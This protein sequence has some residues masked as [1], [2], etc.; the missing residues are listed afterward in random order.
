[1]T[2]ITK[3]T[4]DAFGDEIVA[5]A[6]DVPEMIVIDADVGKSMRTVPFQQKFP[7]QHINV[8]I[9]EQCQ[10]GVAC[11]L[12][13]LDKIPVISTYAVFGSM[14]MVEQIRQ[15]ACYPNLNVKIACSHGGLTPANDGGSHQGIEDMGILRTIPNMT[16]IM[17][18]DYN[19]TRKLFREMVT[20]HKG[21][22]YIRFTRDAI[23]GIY[24]EDIDLK[25]GEANKIFDGNDVTIIAVGDV[26]S[27]AIDA[28]NE[29]C[30]K[31]ISARLLDMHTIK[32]LDNQAVLDALKQTKG[33][34]TVE[35][36]NIMNGLGSAVAEV[37]C[38]AGGGIV[39]RVGIQD[40]FGESGPYEVLLEH[41]GITTEQIVK[42]C[43]DIVRGN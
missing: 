15:S 26:M 9:A 17:G 1:M 19:A 37:V 10:A 25:I 12:A 33:I 4:R 14:R 3:P 29:L 43:R 13:T 30:D 18:A 23:P 8:G 21:P 16:V 28:A 39:K 35:D 20:N 32:P 11:G 38:E 6:H 36:H 22:A 2:K 24:D 31:G 5:L 27:I 42:K 7:Q 41:N 34:V 40:K